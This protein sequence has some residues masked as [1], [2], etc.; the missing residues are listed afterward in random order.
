M[1]SSS[2]GSALLSRCASACSTADAGEVLHDAPARASAV[3]GAE[4]LQ[5]GS[6][7][8]R[9]GA[10]SA[11]VNAAAEPGAA[12]GA[13]TMKCCGRSHA[14]LSASRM[15]SATLHRST[16]CRGSSKLEWP[17]QRRQQGGTRAS[18]CIRRRWTQV[19]KSVS[20]SVGRASQMQREAGAAA[21][22]AWLLSL[23]Q[24]H[25]RHAPRAHAASFVPEQ[26]PVALAEL[27]PSWGA[28]TVRRS[29]GLDGAERCMRHCAPAG[30]LA[31][32]ER[33][34][35]LSTRRSARASG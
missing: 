33:Q 4:T 26:R 28:R 16:F 29:A 6:K 1:L 5:S 34:N 25:T 31:S 23:R 20:V 11:N 32:Q 3:E 27:A 19:A 35:D 12:S 14:S 18:I 9:G 15:T 30:F 10:P 2:S 8:L 13:A 24:D 21:S 7:G 17:R 22:R